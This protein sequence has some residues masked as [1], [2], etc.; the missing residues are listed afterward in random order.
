MRLQPPE[1]QIA[2]LESW[3]QAKR[4]TLARGREDL[5]PQ[6]MRALRSAFYQEY[7]FSNEVTCQSTGLF[8]WRNKVKKVSDLVISN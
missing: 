5:Q 4:G 7:L 2:G 8:A 6:K 3:R 1:R